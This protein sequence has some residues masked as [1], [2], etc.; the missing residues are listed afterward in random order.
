[1]PTSMVVV[2]EDATSMVVVAEDAT[3]MVV[4]A[5]DANKYG[6]RCNKYGSRR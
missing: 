3:S 5:E 4:V 6:R 1:M 2:T